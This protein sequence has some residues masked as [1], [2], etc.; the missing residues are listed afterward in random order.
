M[1]TPSDFGQLQK[2]VDFLCK[3]TG[4]E[5]FDRNKPRVNKCQDIKALAGET[6]QQL[7]HE[8]DFN[9]INHH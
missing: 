5:S 8:N 1:K 6:L 2:D 3:L 9:Q 7:K 4:M